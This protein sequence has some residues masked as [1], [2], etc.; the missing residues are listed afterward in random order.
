MDEGTNALD[1]LDG[2]VIPLH[3]G[4]I[5]VVNRSQRDIDS[6]KSIE[7][8]L[9]SEEEYFKKHPIYASLLGKCGVPYLKVQLRTVLMDHIRSSVP[10]LRIELGNRLKENL[11]EL[12]KLQK[13]CPE[14]FEGQTKFSKQKLIMSTVNS[15]CQEVLELLNGRSNE[16]SFSRLHGPA[17]ISYIFHQSFAENIRSRNLHEISL[18]NAEIMTVIQNVKGLRSG[19]FLP[20]SSFEIILKRHIASLEAPSVECVELVY[21]ELQ[22]LVKAVA[23][24]TMKRF[25]SLFQQILDVSISYLSQLKPLTID[26][27]KKIIQ[28]ETC[29]INIEHPDF[30]PSLQI[31]RIHQYF[32]DNGK[33]T[34]DG[35]MIF[36]KKVKN[37]NVD[38]MDQDVGLFIISREMRLLKATCTSKVE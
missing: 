26:Q 25:P 23:D 21:E 22:K 30:N 9:R 15:Y 12:Q 31:R 1:V 19:I 11:A 29:Y 3:Y 13:T 6:K 27:V 32:Q 2:K 20:D 18:T 37:S 28:M 4:F 36:S 17:R 33:G 38:V 35:D 34:G 24:K 5:G 10:N 16:I 8:A 7:N 14:L